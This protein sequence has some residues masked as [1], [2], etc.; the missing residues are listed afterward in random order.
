MSQSQKSTKIQDLWSSYGKLLRIQNTNG[1]SFIRKQINLPPIPSDPKKK[2][3]YQRK[4]KSYE[5]ERLWYQSEPNLSNPVIPSLLK[6]D[7]LS[8]NFEIE[9]LK[10]KG[11]Q[12]IQKILKPD[13]YRI[14][15]SLANFHMELLNVENNF[16]EHGGYW[17][18]ETRP[19]E[20]KQM[21]NKALQSKAYQLN[22]QLKNAKYKTIIHGDCKLAN[23]LLNKDQVAFVD[24]QYVGSGAGVKDLVTLFASLPED[25]LEDQDDFIDYYFKSMQPHQNY[26]T[27]LDEEWRSLYPIAWA[28][29]LRFLDGWV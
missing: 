21:S 1:S 10:P 12:I 23:I 22:D 18:L 25:F 2:F 15:S 24:F 17:H 13:L 4:K 9:D 27:D 26:S 7:D 8:L 14:I 3:D 6:I 5:V 16:W 29:Y 28:D 11:F 20:L 19:Y